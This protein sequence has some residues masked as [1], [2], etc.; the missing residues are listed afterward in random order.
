MRHVPTGSE[1]HTAKDRLAGTEVYGSA[2]NDNKPWSI[3]FDHYGFDSFKFESGNK[4]HWFVISKD[5][6]LKDFYD[7]ELR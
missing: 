7:C 4:E 5:D 6:L 1:W 3:K 2:S